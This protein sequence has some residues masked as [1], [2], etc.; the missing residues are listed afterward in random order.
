MAN[1]LNFKNITPPVFQTIVNNMVMAIPGTPQPVQA[2]DGTIQGH[3]EHEADFGGIPGK[4]ELDY[5]WTPIEQVL[6]MT[7]NKPFFVPFEPL[8][9]KLTQVVDEAKNAVLFGR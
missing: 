1:T 4:I 3:V 8:Q 5:V 7:I 9:Q 6:V 2:K